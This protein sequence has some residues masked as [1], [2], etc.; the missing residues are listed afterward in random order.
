MANK[1]TKIVTESDFDVAYLNYKVQ[2][3]VEAMETFTNEQYSHLLSQR[4]LLLNEECDSAIVEKIIMPLLEMDNDKTGKTI[5]IYI[6]SVGGSVFDT[7]PLCNIIENLKTPTEIYVLGYAYS[8]G[9]LI[10]MSGF[11]NPKVKTLCYPFSTAL[12]HGGSNVI[13]GTSKQVKD[14]YKFNEKFELRIK[15]FILSHTNEN[16]TEKDYEE[17][18]NGYEHYMDSTEMKNIGLIDEIIG[19]K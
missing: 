19:E 15:D 5:K 7:L 4:I 9:A 2:K 17:V 11:N 8:M 18:D 13:G 12:I 16:F 1:N 14:Y 6:S 3:E 10:L